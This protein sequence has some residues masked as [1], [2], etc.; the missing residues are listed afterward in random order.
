MLETKQ[1]NETVSDE[2]KK[3]LNIA[4]DIELYSDIKKIIDENMKFTIG[5]PQRTSTFK[6]DM[7]NLYFKKFNCPDKLEKHF[8]EAINKNRERILLDMLES[9][10]DNIKGTDK[11]FKEIYDTIMDIDD[12]KAE[13]EDDD[14]D[15][16]LFEWVNN[17]HM[18]CYDEGFEKIKEFYIKY[19]GKEEKIIKYEPSESISFL[20]ME[21]YG[22]S[23]VT[24]YFLRNSR[25][26]LVYEDGEFYIYEL[27]ANG[28][29]IMKR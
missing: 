8:I 15:E 21:D 5:D 25:Q 2:T 3:V 14:D 28:L 11:E 27:N 6:I 26:Y 16:D 24:D 19:G 12:N 1:Y 7:S 10:K 29:L 13:F 20:K 17:H 23:V 18:I 9:I 4:D 22:K